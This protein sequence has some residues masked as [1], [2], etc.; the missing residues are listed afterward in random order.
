M[1]AFAEIET[2]PL[3]L[4]R[5]KTFSDVHMG[6]IV[7]IEYKGKN[8]SNKS[9]I[10]EQVLSS[11]GCTVLDFPKDEVAP[12][13]N[14]KIKVSLNTAQKSGMIEKF[15]KVYAKGFDKPLDLKFSGKVLPQKN[16]HLKKGSAI[17]SKKCSACHANAGMHKVGYQLYLADCA[18]CHGVMR[19]GLSAPALP[20]SKFKHDS[21]KM[22]L[23]QMIA[24][25]SANK[26]MP[27]FSEKNGGPLGNLIK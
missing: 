4:E 9:V 27:G 15:V 16:P 2:F 10:V 26:L 19:E 24:H 21:T 5:E 13:G 7:D 3:S 6:E 11:C 17:F 22:Y 8:T 23:K 20:E 12:G 18:S 1:I 25:G 14:V